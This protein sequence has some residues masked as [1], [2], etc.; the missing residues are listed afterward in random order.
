V[1]LSCFFLQDDVLFENGENYFLALPSPFTPS[2]GFADSTLL[3][4]LTNLREFVVVAGSL[5][6]RKN[7]EVGF[8]PSSL[9][10]FVRVSSSLL[11]PS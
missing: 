11:D 2:H 5:E 9:F 3:R 7:L 6:C 4:S 10:S 1:S 8:P